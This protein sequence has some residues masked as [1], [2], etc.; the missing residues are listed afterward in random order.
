M[1]VELILYVLI[2]LLLYF[3]DLFFFFTN[4]DFALSSDLSSGFEAPF[5]NYILVILF[6]CL[7]HFREMV[8]WYPLVLIFLQNVNLY[9]V[10]KLLISHK[11]GWSRLMMVPPVIILIVGISYNLLAVISVFASYVIWEKS[12]WKYYKALSLLAALT[13]SFF[14]LELAII[15][16]VFIF[17]YHYAF[18]DRSWKWGFR[19]VL[20]FVLAITLNISLVERFGSEEFKS[21]SQFNS[22]RGILH[23]FEFKVSQKLL[24]E[25]G[26]SDRDLF[27]FKK[28]LFYDESKFNTSTLSLI[29]LENQS[30]SRRFRPVHLA[31]YFSTFSFL[32]L[33]FWILV[34][35]F[36]NA[37]LKKKKLDTFL[38]ATASFIVYALLLFF[39]RLPDRLVLPL[40]LMLVWTVM[41][42]SNSSSSFPKL[43]EVLIVFLFVFMWSYSLVSLVAGIREAS[44]SK[45]YNNFIANVVS[46][47]RSE[48]PLVL[49]GLDR[50]VSNYPPALTRNDYLKHIV[51]FGWQIFSPR[52]YSLLKAPSLSALRTRLILNEVEILFFHGKRVKAKELIEYYFRS[53]GICFKDMS[54]YSLIRSCKR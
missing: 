48:K 11:R 1:H 25:I 19:L 35:S 24:K 52:Y 41:D 37:A 45:S 28:F 4:D 33:P 23:G 7:Y 9:I 27:Y 3:F 38:F 22:K 14:R 10:Y 17:V 43:G 21:Y 53:D 51:P 29:N 40:F 20:C 5:V 46:E 31:E 13:A 49:F 30:Y 36:C 47:Y 2:L 12:R 15:S 18:I 50:F 16:G 32:A 39:L 54:D 34:A 44:K 6:R 26:W 8:D 42:D